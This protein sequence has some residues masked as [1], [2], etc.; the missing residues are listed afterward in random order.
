LSDLAEDV[1]VI[2]KGFWVNDSKL[3]LHE[4]HLHG[5]Q[6][7]RESTDVSS[8]EYVIS[9]PNQPTQTTCDSQAF[10]NENP[11]RLKR[12]FEDQDQGL[13]FNEITKFLNHGKSTGQ[14]QKCVKLS[15]N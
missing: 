2:G 7:E 1:D 15:Y 8:M 13:Y 10:K 12:C 6:F 14:L 4:E 9:D 5:H 11:K 3:Q